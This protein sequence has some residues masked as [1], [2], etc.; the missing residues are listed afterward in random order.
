M[1]NPVFKLLPQDGDEPE[2]L[3]ELPLTGGPPVRF[4]HVRPEDQ[5]LITEAIRTA[6]RETLLHRFFSPIRSVSPDMLRQMLSIDRTNETCIVGVT[7]DH[8]V[9]RIIC[10]A[11]YVKLSQAGAAEIALTV[12]D[13]FQ[14]RGLGTFLLKLLADLARTDG[15]RQF[16]ADVMASNQKMLNLF[17]KAA[18]GPTTSHRMGDV[19]HVIIDLSL[20]AQQQS[21]L[22]PKMR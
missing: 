10:G 19:Y 12:H 11:R 2:W 17:R 15:I 22:I 20:S 21:D 1:Q 3:A 9:G 7:E 16:E 6:S 8:S 14:H 4:R 5:P 18:L 13:E